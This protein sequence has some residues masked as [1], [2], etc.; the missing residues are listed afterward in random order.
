M[1]KLMSGWPQSEIE[2]LFPPPRWKE[3]N[4]PTQSVWA[5]AYSLHNIINLTCLRFISLWTNTQ[6]G[7]DRDSHPTAARGNSSC[8]KPASSRS[9]GSGQDRPAALARA[10]YSLTVPSPAPAAK[11][12]LR[13]GRRQSHFSLKIS[14]NFLS[15]LS[16]AS[17]P[18]AKGPL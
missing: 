7:I 2:E 4:H 9:S 3:V 5:C 1:K 18:S 13:R 14:R 10:T 11:A 17:D 12:I 15:S 6:S 16:S 8:S